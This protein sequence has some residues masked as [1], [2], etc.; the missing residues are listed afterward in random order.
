MEVFDLRVAV[1]FLMTYCTHTVSVM[2]NLPY[3]SCYEFDFL[4]DWISGPVRSRVR[5]FS[6][7]SI[8]VHRTS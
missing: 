7:R 4:D 3:S 1:I 6:A 5:Y 8:V 2:C